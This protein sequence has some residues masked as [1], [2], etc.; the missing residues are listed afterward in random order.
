MDPE[1][2]ARFDRLD[3]K[4]DDVKTDLSDYKVVMAQEKTEIMEKA[5]TAHYRI[6]DHL[7]NHKDN[8]NN[9]WQLWV[10]IV[11]LFVGGVITAIMSA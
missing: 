6:D 10:A 4:V 5:K 7:E 8:K 9:S 2:T 3:D 11:T 1:F